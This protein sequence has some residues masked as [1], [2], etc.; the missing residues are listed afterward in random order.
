VESDDEEEEIPFQ[1]LI[2]LQG[3]VK[4]E[5]DAMLTHR[6]DNATVTQSAEYL[7]CK[8]NVVGSSPTSGPTL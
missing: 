6:T 2:W 1:E 7:F 3:L 4:N 8:E 5:F